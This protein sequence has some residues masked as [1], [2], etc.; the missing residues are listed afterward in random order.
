MKRGSLI[1]SL[2]VLAHLSVVNLVYYLFR[3]EIL[4]NFIGVFSYNIFWLIVA[5]MIGSRIYYSD[6]Q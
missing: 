3:T 2:S 4:L 6:K 5:V 1:L